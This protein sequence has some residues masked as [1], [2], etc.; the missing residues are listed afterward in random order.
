M[1]AFAEA[2][3]NVIG[4]E[5]GYTDDPKDSGGATRYGIT[6]R[7]ARAHGYVGDMRNLPLG[8]AQAIYRAQ[9]WDLLRLDEIAR[10]SRRI[11][12]ELFDTAVNMGVGVAG[13][14]LQR[15]LNAFNRNAAD[16]PDVTVD[17]VIGPM[18]VSALRRLL[19]IRG[20]DGETVILRA[21]NS[22][23]GARYIE[24]AESRPK[25]ESFAYGWMLR[26]VA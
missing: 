4:I 11:A 5:G 8:T 12:H 9:Y 25:D 13:G 24:L 23:Q 16:Y 18:T 21:L 15:S 20:G 14:F 10:F 7:V 1:D 2:F 22:L 17:N 19:A 3:E 6:E 26:R